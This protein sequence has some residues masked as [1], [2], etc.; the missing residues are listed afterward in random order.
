MLVLTAQRL[1]RHVPRVGQRSVDLVK[2]AIGARA[3]AK[4]PRDVLE[5]ALIATERGIRAA[6]SAE[7]V[8]TMQRRTASSGAIQSSRAASIAAPRLRRS[9]FTAL[10]GG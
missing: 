6:Y 2:I 5:D 8:A 9:V 4:A 7:T 10:S 3:V 1:Q